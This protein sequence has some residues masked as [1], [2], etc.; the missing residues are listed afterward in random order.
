MSL[1]YQNAV[2]LMARI[3]IENL[4]NRWDQTHWGMLRIA[5]SEPQGDIIVDKDGKVLGVG[6]C[7]TGMCAAGW[8]CT[9]S[10][11]PSMVIHWE[12]I[13]TFLYGGNYTV[14]GTHLAD[15]ACR[16]LGIPDVGEVG[17]EADDDGD[18]RWSYVE[19]YPRLFDGPN[20]IGD[21]YREMS[22][23]MVDDYAQAQAAQRDNEA[24]L[25]ADVERRVRQMQ[26]E[27]VAKRT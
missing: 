2:D 5:D 16:W 14:D 10:G 12:K 3:E 15:A 8:A 11:D 18:P 13:D 25:R 22:L 9:I 7:Q 6:S 1:N 4:N 24:R 21:L 26:E 23:W 17:D 27:A 19:G 20:A